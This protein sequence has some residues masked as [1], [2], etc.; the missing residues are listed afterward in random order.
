MRA[1]VWTAGCAKPKQQH[2]TPNLQ[3]SINTRCKMECWK[4]K[5]TC[6]C[7]RLLVGAWQVMYARASASLVLP[8]YSVASQS[9]VAVNMQMDAEFER[10]QIDTLFVWLGAA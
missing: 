1:W 6:G 10:E 2:I 5:A 3:D 9:L 7:W 4:M 8:H